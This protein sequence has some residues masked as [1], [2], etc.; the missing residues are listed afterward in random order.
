MARTTGRRGKRGT[1]HRQRRSSG[2][3]LASR[4]DLRKVCPNPECPSA[5]AADIQDLSQIARDVAP[6]EIMERLG[7]RVARRCRHCG[8]VF[9]RQP[10]KA[11]EPVGYFNRPAGAMAEPVAG[12]EPPLPH[13]APPG[14]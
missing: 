1:A 4:R 12:W 9:V 14:E 6:V 8:I 3:R 2:R 13:H 7:E 5:D 11:N 10:G